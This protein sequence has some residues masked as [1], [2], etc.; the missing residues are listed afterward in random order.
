[1][2]RLARPDKPRILFDGAFCFGFLALFELP[3]GG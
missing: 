3:S 2:E 1:M